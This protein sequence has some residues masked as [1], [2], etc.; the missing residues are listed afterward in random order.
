MPSIQIVP[1][2]LSPL[3]ALKIV[4]PKAGRALPQMGQATTSAMSFGKCEYT[5]VFVTEACTTVGV[6]FNVTVGGAGTALIDVGLYAD[7]GGKTPAPAAKLATVATGLSSS[8]G[9]RVVAYVTT[10][11]PGIYWTALL[12]LGSGGVP[13]VR[14]L[15]GVNPFIHQLNAAAAH[16]AGYTQ[17]GLAALPTTATPAVDGNNIAR[18]VITT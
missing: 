1:P 3:R 10:L 14:S 7:A 17:S 16:A 15:G 18:G 5:P 6:E 12:L 4:P 11:T 13:T 2:S 8:G 9:N